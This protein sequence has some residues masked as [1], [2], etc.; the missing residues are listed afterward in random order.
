MSGLE[1]GR[2]LTGG[3]SRFAVSRGKVA[4]EGLDGSAS[5]VPWTCRAES[6]H[7]PLRDCVR[8]LSVYMYLARLLGVFVARYGWLVPRVDEDADVIDV[9]G[10]SR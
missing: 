1:N 4:V 10:A 8:L 2:T 5:E 7:W 6:G 3:G 9:P